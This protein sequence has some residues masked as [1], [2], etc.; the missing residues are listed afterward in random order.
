[1]LPLQ[2]AWVQS[3]TGE[4]SAWHGQKNPKN[5]KK[6]KRDLPYDRT[7]QLMDIHIYI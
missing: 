5:N 4:L 7:T 3:L 1:M 2:R 6:T